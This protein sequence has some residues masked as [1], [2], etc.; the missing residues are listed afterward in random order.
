MRKEKEQ[1]ESEV[2]FVKNAE[3]QFVPRQ[4]QMPQPM[5]LEVPSKN[6][7][8]MSKIS[9]SIAATP[10]FTKQRTEGE[11]SIVQNEDSQYYSNED[12]PSVEAEIT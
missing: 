6:P 11:T 9:Q 4:V 1:L 7:F 5:Q 10:L 12:V 2:V 3:G 8:D